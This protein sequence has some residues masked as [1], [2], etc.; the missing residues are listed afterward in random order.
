MLQSGSRRRVSKVF[1]PF[2]L[3]GCLTR[4]SGRFRCHYCRRQPWKATGPVAGNGLVVEVYLGDDDGAAGTGG[5]HFPGS[6]DGGVGDD[7]GAAVAVDDKNSSD[8]YPKLSLGRC[9]SC[10]TNSRRDPS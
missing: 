10:S 6:A 1:L 5:V 2:G 8:S 4:V 7:D 9:C 3:F